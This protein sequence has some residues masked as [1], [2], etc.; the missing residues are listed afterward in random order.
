MTMPTYFYG[1]DLQWQQFY[2][3]CTA[4]G[5]V[6]TRVDIKHLDSLQELLKK[7]EKVILSYSSPQC[8]MATELQQHDSETALKAWL[9]GNNA[10]LALKRSYRKTLVLVST[11]ADLDSIADTI[12]PQSLRAALSQTAAK[13]TESLPVL[14][15]LS[16]VLLQQDTDAQQSLATLIVSSL[17]VKEQGTAVYNAITTYKAL[18]S[19]LADLQDT[20]NKYQ[21]LLTAEQNLQQTVTALNNDKQ[22]LQQDITGLN[23]DK[24]N[25]Q[26]EN[27]LILNQLFQVQEELEKYFLHNKSLQRELNQ[28]QEKAAELQKAITEQQKVNADLN[29][30]LQAC[31]KD[32][33]AKQNHQAML[34]KQAEREISKNEAEINQLQRQLAGAS[35]TG[36]QAKA[37]LNAVKN[38]TLWKAIAPVRK[39]TTNSKKKQQQLQREMALINSCPLF[40]IAW[41]LQQNPD[42]AAL[43]KDPI[44]HYL[45]YGAKEG[46]TPGPD[47]DG[48]WYISH[49]PDVAQSGINPLVHYIKFG[50]VEGRQTSPKLLQLKTPN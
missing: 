7:G 17:P 31:Q 16:G 49:Y 45:K 14:S 9:I 15:L 1:P 48:N 41:Y 21:V 47:F 24:Q 28:Q 29:N 36:Q 50:Q 25:L 12:L 44:E 20:A 30:L 23:N 34:L 33:V 40:D 37:E 13:D 39:I 2:A 42:V 27:Q 35:L 22:N 4:K 43:N 11:N 19:Q 5:V 46:R 18:N 3:A 8:I 6:A 38:S 26:Q 10:L 32:A